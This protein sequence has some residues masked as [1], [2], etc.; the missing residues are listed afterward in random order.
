[1]KILIA[2]YR[3]FISG[4]PERYLFNI[5]NAL[6]NR[7]HEVIPFSI[8]YTKNR[9]SPYSNFFVSPLGNENEVYF[10]D[11]RK[12]LKTIWRTAKR[13]FY[14]K[15]VEVATRR[16][17]SDTKPDVAYV[18]HYLRK[19]SPSLLVGLKRAGLPIVVRVSDYAMLC[20]QAHCLRDSQ[21]CEL[22]MGGNLFPSIRYRCIQG[23][24]AA[25]ALNVLATWYHRFRHYFDL[26]DIFVVT[27]LFMYRMMIAAGFPEKH[28]R[29][30]PT[31]VDNEV[32]QSLPTNTR[33][34]VVVF[35]GRVEFIKGVHVLVDAIAILAKER[36][37]VGWKFKIAG[38]G[39]EEYAHT[40]HQKVATACLEEKI[41]FLGEL[42]A[43]DLSNLL[44]HA[45]LSVIPSMWYEN[46]P[47]ALLE[48]YACGTPVI[49]SSLGSLKEAVSEGE[50]GLLF[51]PGDAAQLAEKLAYSWDCREKISEM[52]LKAQRL[53]KTTYSRQQHLNSL[54]ALFSELIE[55]QANS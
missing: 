22:C 31:F 18:L 37:D 24:L 34:D 17:T 14:D 38:T 8:K 12:N 35:A 51:Q 43:D 39:N 47:N 15:E 25:S 28:L 50:S 9:P 45:S 42:Q 3:Y 16:I 41:D 44:S 7:G 10:K 1:M 11:Q 48:S 20:P 30:I 23:N 46:L 53:A 33:Q 36:P 54:T 55:K 2:N 6:E 21:P 49:A 26:I 27:N 19:L 32:F 52:G 40:I 13:L 5:T 29:C 4:G